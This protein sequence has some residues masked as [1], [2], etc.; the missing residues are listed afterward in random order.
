MNDRMD[1]TSPTPADIGSDPPSSAGE[2]WWRAMDHDERVDVVQRTLT[3]I[4][5]A[6]CGAFVFAQLQP[7]EILSD[8]TPAGG[9]MGAHVWAPAF[10]RD[11]LL[12]SGRLTG[13]TPDWYAGFPAMQ[14]YM[15]VPML[16]IV[17]LSYIL[18]Y[19]VAF[20]LVTVAGIVTLPISAWAFGR[21]TRQAFPIPAFMAMGAT[22]FVF[23][24]SYSIY[25]GNAA[26]TLAGEFAFSISLSLALLYLG[27][28]G[29]GLM[30]G[31][32]RALAAGLL[33]L[34]GLTHLIPAFFAV[35]GTLIWML[36]WLGRDLYEAAGS[37][38]EDR[39]QLL[40]VRAWMRAKYLMIMGGVAALLAAFWVLPFYARSRYLNDMGWVKDT[41]YTDFLFW[42]EGASSGGLA[43]Y[44]D[45]VVVLALAAIAA[46]ASI[47][48]R[49]RAGLF[50]L[51]T[52]LTA[53]LAF[54]YMPQGRLWNTRILPIYYLSLLLLAAVGIGL[55]PKVLANVRLRRWMGGLAALVTVTLQLHLV[56]QLPTTLFGH[57]EAIRWDARW[58]PYFY[59]GLAFV[60][61]VAMA[62]IV[63]AG[64][65]IRRWV[66]WSLVAVAVGLQ[67]VMFTG[68]DSLATGLRLLAITYM[69]LAV[70][71]VTAAAE[72]LDALTAETGGRPW[73]T[74][75]AVRIGGASLVVVGLWLYLAL[76][77]QALGPA[78]T[79]DSATGEYHVQGVEF[80][81]TSDDHFVDSWARWNYSGYEE[82][83]RYPEYNSIVTTMAAVGEEH[84]CGRAMWEYS[85]DLDGYGTPMALMLLPHWTD[86]CI[87][88]MEGLYFE[89]STSTPY[90]FI[91]QDQLSEAGSNA[92]RGLP[93]GSGAP[94]AAEFDEGI[95][96]LQMFGVKYYMAYTD[97]LAGYAADHPDLTEVA[98]ATTPCREDL[99]PEGTTTTDRWVVFEVADSELVVPLDYQPVILDNVGDG[100]TCETAS[101]EEDPR[102]RVCEG[103][104]DPAVDYYVDQELWDVPLAESGP[105]D[106]DRIDVDEWLDTHEVPKTALDPVE[107]TDISID[108]DRISF[109]VDEIG[110][111]VVVRSSY[112][113]NWKASGADGPYRITPNLMVVIPTASHVEVY[114]GWTSVDIAAYA[115][116]I[117][118]LGLLVWLIRHT[119]SPMPA[120]PVA[121]WRQRP[122]DDDSEVGSTPEYGATRADESGTSVP[123]L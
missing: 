41:N 69:V 57:T 74:G 29:N 99:C 66:G 17:A 22:L 6:A 98:R 101:Q 52:V 94:D 68:P 111:P 103:W 67:V 24:R 19:G 113:P 58:A 89:A 106:W 8:T 123:D 110:V 80:L 78:G 1:S 116:S 12:P 48:L 2:N 13:W 108:Y 14:F 119:Q 95:K 121:I 20:K 49:N 25:G 85:G 92:Q 59:V 39:W 7:S 3:F 77:L 122:D 64:T 34:C 16:V 26:S 11:Y 63:D 51:A 102:L 4:V 38:E 43:N 76:P 21:L 75:P 46:V 96:H 32:R 71:A 50:F 61:L 10:M 47:A 107:V 27:V 105:D 79:F 53:A 70:I 84:G 44:P 28:V 83:P 33:A 73:W 93:Y 23:D 5:V 118:G 45:I 42:R 112:F 37:I 54:R 30:T 115:L 72:I 60:T 88:S 81:G 62:E 65:T 36:L 15:V 117:L 9:D 97:L 35:A 109:D 114:Y 100:H 56:H 87:G 82:K 104:L 31:R 90:H 120:G 18:P 40:G 91:N 55:L 86:G